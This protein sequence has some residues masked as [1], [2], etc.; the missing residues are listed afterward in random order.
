MRILWS[1]I[2]EMRFVWLIV[3]L[4][5]ILSSIFL[6]GCGVG[7]EKGESILAISEEQKLWQVKTEMEN[8]LIMFDEG[9]LTNWSSKLLKIYFKSGGT[10]RRKAAA[11]YSFCQALLGWMYMHGDVSKRK[12]REAFRAALKY[13][14]EI[15]A[16]LDEKF[17]KLLVREL[18]LEAGYYKNYADLKNSLAAFE[19]ELR[20]EIDRTFKK[21]LKKL[22]KG[23]T[24][25]GTAVNPINFKYASYPFNLADVVILQLRAAAVVGDV[26]YFLEQMSRI[27]NG[28]GELAFN[29]GVKE[30]KALFEAFAGSWER[31]ASDLLSFRSP[32]IPLGFFNQEGVWL[33][34]CAYSSIGGEYLKEIENI[35]KLAIKMRY[36]QYFSTK[37]KKFEEVFKQPSYF[38]KYLELYNAYKNK[39]AD[40][41]KR[42][43]AAI[44]QLDQNLKVMPI[45]V[46]KTYVSFLLDRAKEYGMKDKADEL[47]NVL[48]NI[49]TFATQGRKKSRKKSFFKRWF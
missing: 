32:D 5:G 13:S 14:K 25:P 35:D 6:T 7:K 29:N 8:S 41:K 31:V 12:I 49:S 24:F 19:K 28:T 20:F 38:L 1:D 2:I 21:V 37:S 27:E 10:V 30:V 34:R 45:G 23:W 48:K 44:E 4:V 43:V 18:S 46:A 33:L 47:A 15:G 16:E 39:V 40:F 9:Q 42:L 26:A 22:D 17:I 11:Y 36:S 3:V